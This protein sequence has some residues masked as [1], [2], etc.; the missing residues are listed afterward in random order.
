MKQWI[1][2]IA[3]AS[4]LAAMAMALTPK[5]SVRQVTRL[6]CGLMCALA[7]AAPVTKLDL[8]RISAGIAKYEQRAREITSQAEEEGKMLDRTYI[9]ERCQAYI[10]SKAAQLGA[11]VTEARV[12]A[13]WEEDDMVWYPWTVTLDC[14]RH[15]ALAGLIE[16]ELGIPAERQE[17][18]ADG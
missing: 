5:G 11:P 15:A 6:V 18:S 17:W 1:S 12:T 3:A 9:E 10:L 2:G 14:P 13:R 8:G 4:V 7:V 16:G